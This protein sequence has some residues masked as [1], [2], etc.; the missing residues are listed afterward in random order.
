[1]SPYLVKALHPYC[2]RI[3]IQAIQS[4][5]KL[6]LTD[7]GMAT[8]KDVRGQCLYLRFDSLGIMRGLSTYVDHEDFETFYF[9]IKLF[10][11]RRSRLRIIYI[12][13]DNPEGFVFRQCFHHRTMT[14]IPRMPDFIHILQMN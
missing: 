7:M 5:I 13:M 4:G 14:Y 3:H 1:Q 12:P 2:S 6:D 9:E 11:V 10:W 8:Y